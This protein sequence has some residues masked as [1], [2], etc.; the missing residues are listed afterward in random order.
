MNPENQAETP[1]EFERRQEEQGG[2]LA[3]MPMQ[4]GYISADSRQF[5]QLLNEF[6]TDDSISEH[7]REEFMH[8][9]MTS[10]HLVFANLSQDDVIIFLRKFFIIRGKFLNSMIS[11]KITHRM[12]MKLDNLEMAFRAIL[13]RATGPSRERVLQN[14]QVRQSIT[15]SD[16]GGKQKKPGFFGRLLGFGGKRQGGY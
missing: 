1:Y 14:T 4:P 11:Y 13:T 3:P 10:R 16:I 5:V 7:I 6:I 12:L 8:F 15:T 9:G 2:P